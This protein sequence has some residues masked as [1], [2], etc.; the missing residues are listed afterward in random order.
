MINIKE[1]NK[2]TLMK[3]LRIAR[4]LSYSKSIMINSATIER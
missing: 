1:L 2:D 3:Q 4:Q